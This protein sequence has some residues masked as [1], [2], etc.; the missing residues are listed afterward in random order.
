M[1]RGQ[2]RLLP[3]LLAVVLV[4]LAT[5]QDAGG[6]TRRACGGRHIERYPLRLGSYGVR[7]CN[8]Q[9]LLKGN[10]KKWSQF[11]PFAGRVN[12]YFGFRTRDAVNYTKYH[13]GY[14]LSTILKDGSIGRQFM[15]IL[16]GQT[17]RPRDYVLRAKARY[18]KDAAERRKFLRVGSR[19]QKVCDLQ[20]LLQGNS[21]NA[22]RKYIHPYRGRVDC[23]FGR[24]TAKAVRVAKW[25]LGYPSSGINGSVG[26]NFFLILKGKRARPVIWVGRASKRIRAAIAVQNRHHGIIGSIISVA[27]SQVGV[28]EYPPGSNRGYQV[29]QYTRVT[30]TV[31]LAWC[32]AFIQWVYLHSIGHVLDQDSALVYYLVSWGRAHG[33]LRAIPTPGY[34][35]AFL[36]SLGHIGIVT[37]VYAGS[38][39]TIEGNTSNGVYRRHY[40]M[41]SYYTVFINPY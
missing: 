41:G 17:K 18:R 3:I 13:L 26:H 33:R 10:S 6:A 40:R 20:Y 24:A 36:H 39:D 2:L 23:R 38:F 31:G 8:V 14:P 9:Y 12:G 29:D 30:H 37:R 1:I 5:G 25:R 15:R 22:Y 28:H 4:G 34:A 35:V 11:H 7:T 27:S 19:G 32:A 21:P 16:Q